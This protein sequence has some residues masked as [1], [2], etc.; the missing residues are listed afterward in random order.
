MD[1]FLYFYNIILVLIYGLLMFLYFQLFFSKR[2]PLHLW[3][4]LLFFVYLADELYY[5]SLEFIITLPVFYQKFPVINTLFRLGI[6]LILLI[7]YRMILA[8]IL[9]MAPP[10]IEWIFMIFYSIYRLGVSFMP[11]LSLIP[12]W[13]SVCLAILNFLPHIWMV[14]ISFR[15]ADHDHTHFS[16]AICTLVRLT[17]ILWLLLCFGCSYPFYFGDPSGNRMVFIE[18]ISAF[19]TFFAVWHLVSV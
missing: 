7:C 9:Q 10:K 16:S 1:Y 6:N 15:F 14:Y 5:S 4:A 19:A 3:T 8:S 12:L 13:G 17:V 2:R 18:I 11:F